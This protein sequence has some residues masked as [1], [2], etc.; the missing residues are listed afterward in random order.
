MRCEIR[1]SRSAGIGVHLHQNKPVWLKLSCALW[2]RE[3]VRK[4]I[5]AQSRINLPIRTTGHYL[6]CWGMTPKKPVKHAYELQP[7]QIQAKVKAEGAEIYLD[8]ETGLRN[9]SQH[10]RSYAPKGKAPVIRLNA[11]VNRSA[12]YRRSPT[13]TRSDSGSSMAK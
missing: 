11:N 4:L 12:R 6:K 2:T 13:K 7:P 1:C 3:S 5:K 9:D 10:E 8:D